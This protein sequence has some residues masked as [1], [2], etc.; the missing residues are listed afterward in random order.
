MAQYQAHKIIQLLQFCS[1]KARTEMSHTGLQEL[2]AKLG[3]LPSKSALERPGKEY[4]PN[5]KYLVDL[6]SDARV[7]L[8]S[9]GL[10]TK[11]ESYIDLLAAYGGFN[12]WGDWEQKLASVGEYLP[13][14]D[15]DLSRFRQLEVLIALPSELEKQVLPV[16]QFVKRASGVPINLAVCREEDPEEY[17]K[18]LA[19]LTKENPFVIGVFPV[20]LK[21]LPATIQTGTWQEFLECGTIIPVWLDPSDTWQTAPPFIPA[22]KQQLVIGGLPGMLISILLIQTYISESTF[23][24]PQEVEKRVDLQGNWK[25]IENVNNNSSG[26]FYQG[27]GENNIIQSITHNHGKD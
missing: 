13:G 3:A 8:K 2:S 11:R 9:D 12:D 20:S 17:A 18:W 10:V 27:Q 24:Q 23:H 25:R 15:T 19:A 4:A 21:E 5:E 7:A 6:L 1:W 16:F 14:E 26:F 22:L